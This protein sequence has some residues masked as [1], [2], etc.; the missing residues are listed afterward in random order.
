MREKRQKTEVE[1]VIKLFSDDTEKVYLEP[2]SK[3]TLLR[4]LLKIKR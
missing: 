3:D 4:T 1:G 2:S